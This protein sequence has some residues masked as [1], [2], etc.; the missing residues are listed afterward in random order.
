M[1]IDGV[2]PR[3][4]AGRKPLAGRVTCPA[5]CRALLLLAAAIAGSG[6]A[7]RVAPPRPPLPAVTFVRPADPDAVVGLTPTGVDDLKRRDAIWRG[8]VEQLEA[9]IRGT[10]R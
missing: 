4:A 10:T 9:I 8:H 2:A 5:A 3:D 7:R 6:C 1:S